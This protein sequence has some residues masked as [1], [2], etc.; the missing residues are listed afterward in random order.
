MPFGFPADVGTVI[1]FQVSHEKG[2][3]LLTAAPVEK[4]SLKM[5]E[6][7]RTWVKENA[8]L[9]SAKWPDVLRHGLFIVTST[10]ATAN[11]RLNILHSS[12][13]T[14]TAGLRGSVP[15]IGGWGPSTSCITAQTDSGWIESAAENVGDAILASLI[16]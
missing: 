11:A 8:R 5:E 2:A 13:Q 4:R 14:V 6:P 3:V 12:C 9:I 1:Q 7:F 15:G 16:T 10:F